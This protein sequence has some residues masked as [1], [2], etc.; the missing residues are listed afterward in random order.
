M[1]KKCSVYS[2]QRQY[3][4]YQIDNTPTNFFLVLRFTFTHTFTKELLI[5]VH[6]YISV[7]GFTIKL[8]KSFAGSDKAQN[9]ALQLNKCVY[10]SLK[11]LSHNILVLHM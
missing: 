3:H 5:S 7:L 2:A 1:L 11:I 9:L 8:S 4:F 10:C 6:D